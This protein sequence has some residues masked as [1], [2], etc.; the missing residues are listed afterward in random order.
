M[1]KIHLLSLILIFIIS[2]TD[3]AVAQWSGLG[4]G[5]NGQVSAI[6]EF[7]NELYV[8]GKFTANGT[9]ATTLN[10]IAKWNG[11]S[12]S[13]VGSGF[14][15]E[16]KTLVVFNNQ[17]Y[18]GGTFTHSG[19][20]ALNHVAKLSGGTWVD[21]AQGFNSNVNALYVF[22]DALYAGGAF[23]QSGATA[24]NKI[25]KLVSNSWTNPNNTIVTGE[26]KA[27]AQHLGNLYIGGFPF[28]VLR[29]DAATWTSIGALSGQV[30]AMG[31][32]QYQSSTTKYLYIGGDFTVAPSFGLCVYN[33]SSYATP[34]NQYLQ[35]SKVYAI[36]PTATKL[37]T[38]GQFS[39]SA[40]WGAGQTRVSNNISQKAYTTPWD[41][42]SATFSAGATVFALGTYGNRLVAGGTFTTINGVTCTNIAIRSTTVGI[43]EISDNVTDYT[44]FPSPMTDMATLRITTK[45]PLIKPG[46][47]IFDNQSRLISSLQSDYTQ[48]NNETEFSIRRNDLSAGLYYYVVTD[49][50]GNGI[51]SDKFIIQ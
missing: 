13:A 21:V 10:H 35:P 1:K 36:L 22:Q 27:I 24:V 15:E 38:G 31:S 44:F 43:D 18:A 26:V 46:L 19:A 9:N 3:F 33:G 25:A 2:Q 48:S 23:S 4:N 8:G 42:M 39:V 51:L 28:G 45:T 30:Y 41:T 11:T 16:V 50:N 6:V 34:F 20:T 29:M 49:E 17:L 14:D 40:T 32:F 12:W 37:F 47:S 7:Q 5:L